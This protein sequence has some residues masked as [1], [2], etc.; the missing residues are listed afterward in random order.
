[1]KKPEIISVTQVQLDTMLVLAKPTFAPD[2]YELLKA[3]FE[4]YA[5]VM[6]A[7]Q[8]AKTSLKR[9]RQ[10][11][12]G[13]KTESKDKVLAGTPDA[14]TG[15]EALQASGVTA[16][17]DTPADK[18]ADTPA[19]P[20]RKKRKG[21]GRN[22]ASAYCDSPVIE[23]KVP[24]LKSGDL[25][26]QCLTGKVYE[27]P[28]KLIVKVIGQPP[29]G[30]TRVELEQLR[31][32]ICDTVFTAPMPDGQSTSPKYDHSCAAM[33][34]VLRYGTGMP[35][36]RLEG[37]QASL[38]V[39]LPDSTQWDIVVKALPAPKAI[40]TELIKQAA[41][42]PLLHTDDT[43]TK[44]LSLI[45]QRK[46]LEAMGQTPINKAINTTGIIAVFADY[47][48]ALFLS[49]H[50]HAGDNLNLVLAQRALELEPPI[51]MSDALSSNFTHSDEFARIV[52]NCMAHGRRKFV[53]I[54]D[55]FPQEC[56]YVIE[57]FA[58]VYGHDAHCRKEG[59]T[60][61]QRLL[62]HQT[63]S[64][65][66]M[67]SLHQWMGDQLKQKLVEPNSELGGALRYMLN[68]WNALT[69]FLRK[70][71]APLDNNIC[72][73]ALK[74]AIRHRKNS[75]FYNTLMGALVG[76]VYMSIIHT[77][78]LCHINPFVYLQALQIHSKDVME[79]PALWLPWNY[80]QQLDKLKPNTSEASLGTPKPQQHYVDDPNR[81][82]AG[83]ALVRVGSPP[84]SSTCSPQDSKVLAGA[85]ASGQK[86]KHPLD[87]LFWNIQN[88][89]PS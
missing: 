12:F 46:V 18:P 69:L 22:A 30:A 7:L 13:A 50:N 16:P 44:I 45:E 38:N 54:I 48:V 85:A 65:E 82:Q 77:C 10:M 51:Q 11:L 6:R 71:G 31:C 81:R 88:P 40:F 62:Y 4:T 74:R 67:Q 26:P 25:C 59:L 86:E 49:G 8:N 57:V 41:Q 78:E 28:P 23:I 55:H 58:Q 61:E 1:M 21:H 35:F 60:P 2:Q 24:D 14:G 5:Y 37:L 53:E 89:C 87:S 64:G 32:R 83:A 39:P 84:I 75:L 79:H 19:T 66:P 3:V 36:Y 29:L 52:A 15:D 73:R 43:P 9:F 56:R 72:E 47:K 42:A 68:N 70:A 27:S 76:D 17:S 80:R 33:L 20:E 34:A 63:H